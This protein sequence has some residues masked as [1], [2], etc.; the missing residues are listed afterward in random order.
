MLTQVS[1]VIEN[2]D[3]LMP[4]VDLA[5]VRKLV[6]NLVGFEESGQMSFDDIAQLSA[7]LPDASKSLGI[8]SLL[9]YENS[10]ENFHLAH[11][12]LGTGVKATLAAVIGAA[13]ALLL[14]FFKL[15]RDRDYVAGGPDK[16][17]RGS[18]NAAVAYRKE[19]LKTT[20]VLNK[21]VEEF[22][23]QLSGLASQ[24]ALN[25]ID[26]TVY[27]ELLSLTSVLYNNVRN[28]TV[29]PVP[30][31]ERNRDKSRL[32]E[33]LFA[34]SEALAPGKISYKWAAPFNFF[35]MTDQEMYKHTRFME[36][37][38]RYAKTNKIFETTI[39][40][41]TIALSGVRYQVKRVQDF[42]GPD[43]EGQLNRI[44]DIIENS[45]SPNEMASATGTPLGQN[46][47]ETFLNI[48]EEFKEHIAALFGT[49]LYTEKSGDT[50]FKNNR[51]REYY[52]FLT[53][54]TDNEVGGI[55]SSI[56]AMNDQCADLLK[57]VES[58]TVSGGRSSFFAE[59]KQMT[60]RLQQKFEREIFMPND[61]N[62]PYN[63]RDLEH[64]KELKYVGVFIT[65]LVRFMADFARVVEYN[66]RFDD[67]LD[68]METGMTNLC[69]VLLNIN[70][71][72]RKIEND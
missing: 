7:L 49:N 26:G 40:E 53:T 29:V 33:I 54:E 45:F 19:F 4:E 52:E 23:A 32:G 39:P 13:I 61:P 2:D 11:E 60:E 25:A 10:T 58:V 15:R 65:G 28:F 36:E 3:V 72:L 24:G 38:F 46:N 59:A 37:L 47:I 62:T 22:R 34:Y 41:L 69:K 50:V 8:E 6:E 35:F 63:K 44:Y 56:R 51:M 5:R 17:V 43:T 21:Q 70:G 16:T 9:T 18:V 14:R 66:T 71:V 20:P 27:P 57:I 48:V 30:G 1:T 68:G 12:A 67:Q 31:F 55:W 64:H 42:E